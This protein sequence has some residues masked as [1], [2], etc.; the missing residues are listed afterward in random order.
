MKKLMSAKE[1]FLILTLTL[2][3]SLSLIFGE[4]YVPNQEAAALIN[5]VSETIA[6]LPEGTSQSTATID[7]LVAKC[8][9]AVKNDGKYFDAYV[10]LSICYLLKQELSQGIETAEKAITLAPS[11]PDGYF[12]RGFGYFI[13]SLQGDTTSFAKVIPDL[14]KVLSLNPDYKSPTVM[15]KM[16]E[17]P[18]ILFWKGLVH[19]E[20]GESEKAKEVLENLTKKY[21]ESPAAG[22][23]RKELE[24]LEQPG[25]K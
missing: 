16:T 15:G 9:E 14:D 25:V 7:S 20:L 13:S 10:Y 19:I 24:K 11:N 22:N 4:N 1:N 6:N 5:E 17:V 12:V 23:A 8:E 18:D 21:P 3:V 2:F